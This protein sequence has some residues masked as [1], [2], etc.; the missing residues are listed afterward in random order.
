MKPGRITR[1]SQTA[2]CASV[3]FSSS[4]DYSQAVNTERDNITAICCFKNIISSALKDY[5]DSVFTMYV[6]YNL[7]I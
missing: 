4:V 1:S 3:G 7:Y 5:S 2:L 6:I